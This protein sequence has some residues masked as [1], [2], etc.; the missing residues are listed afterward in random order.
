[1]TDATSLI[2]EGA[3]PCL[4]GDSKYRLVVNIV[5]MI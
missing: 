3:R 2:G 5:I 1:L 4:D